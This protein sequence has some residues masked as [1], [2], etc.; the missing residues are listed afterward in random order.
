MH[1]KNITF[2]LYADN[3]LVNRTSY[4]LT[5]TINWSVSSDGLYSFNATVFDYAE[6]SNYSNTRYVYV[7][8]HGPVFGASNYSSNTSSVILNVNAS[9]TP[10]GVNLVWAR[11]VNSSGGAG[12]YT[13]TRN[14]G[15]SASGLYNVT[16]NNLASGD[17]NLT[18]YGN[19][20]IGTISNSS[21]SIFD[22]YASANISF[23]ISSNNTIFEFYPPGSLTYLLN[24]TISNGSSSRIVKNRTYDLK[25]N[26]SS[27]IISLRNVNVSS[28]SYIELDYI[29]SSSTSDISLYKLLTIV[30]LE[31]NLSFGNASVS[32]DY[33][34]KFGTYPAISESALTAH[35]CTI[36]NMTNHSCSGS[37]S[38]VSGASV[39]TTIDK[40]SIETS[41]FSGY[42]VT[43][44]R[45][46]NGICE[47]NYGE[48]TST[49][50]ADCGTG[51]TTPSSSS[52][53]SGGGGGGGT[54]TTKEVTFSTESID[55]EL[56]VGE[57][58]SYS[59]TLTNPTGQNINLDLSIEGDAAEIIDMEK[60]VTVVATA[61]KT[62]VLNIYGK[63]EKAYLG[64]FVVQ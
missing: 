9:D 43:E 27:N 56:T 59:L 44:N 22:V 13:M 55:E 15:G 16:I 60:K 48:T 51:G 25:V 26:V 64:Y 53:S 10:S 40:V 21:T 31:S 34:D 57:S 4:S 19:D 49:C 35:K 37:W 45:C 38:S 50:S 7:D 3:S 14:L 30:G 63:K 6:N 62:I 47:A 32:L 58:K 18:Y 2:F 1:I 29:N 54:T 33:S 36:W 52:S 41:S 5:N 17:Y 20:S 28:G 42:A 11:I 46:G 61:V 24:F 12:N 23:N 8:T 39:N